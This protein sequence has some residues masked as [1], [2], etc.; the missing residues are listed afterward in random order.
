MKRDALHDIVYANRAPQMP[1]SSGEESLTSGMLFECRSA[2]SHVSV[3]RSEDVTR[4]MVCWPSE[5]DT[6]GVLFSLYATGGALHYLREWE[7]DRRGS[8]LIVSDAAPAS[9]KTESDSQ[10]S[11]AGADLAQLPNVHIDGPRVISHLEHEGLLQGV[12]KIVRALRTY[13]PAAGLLVGLGDSDIAPEPIMVS[14]TVEGDP[15]AFYSALSRFDYEWWLNQDDSLRDL[16]G[17]YLA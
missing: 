8:N 5:G 7:P 16:V 6:E 9:R 10:G 12:L 17:I 11:L 4:K 13:F 2:W 15:E 1:Y 3:H 14:I